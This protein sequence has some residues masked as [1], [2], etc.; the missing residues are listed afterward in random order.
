[1]VCAFITGIWRAPYSKACPSRTIAKPQPA[2]SGKPYAAAHHK[3]GIP[4]KF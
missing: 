3:G 4:H 1:M 2:L